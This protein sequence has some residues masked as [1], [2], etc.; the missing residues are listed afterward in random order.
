MQVW[1]VSWDS[2]AAVCSL[3]AVQPSGQ[4]NLSAPVNSTKA[5]STA[6]PTILV[7]AQTIT[8]SS[9]PGHYTCG[10]TLVFSIVERL[11][12]LAGRFRIL[13]LPPSR[14]QGRVEAA[15]PFVRTTRPVNVASWQSVPV[16]SA[17]IRVA[18]AVPTLPNV[19]RHP[20]GELNSP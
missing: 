14:P 18:S 3:D 20:R 10:T 5:A 2:V 16:K 7:T 15:Y 13:E 11:F 8:Q 17:S 19:P 4:L 9:V 6:T 12:E 1:A